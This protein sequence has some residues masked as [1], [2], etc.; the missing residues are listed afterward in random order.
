[1]STL[2]LGLGQIVWIGLEFLWLS[3]VSFLQW[4]YGFVGLALAVLPWSPSM[5]AYL[6]VE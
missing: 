6:S 3:E 4:L 5:R 1:M 2:L